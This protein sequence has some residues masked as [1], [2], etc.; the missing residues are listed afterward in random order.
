MS[1]NISKI[2]NI[3]DVN[4]ISE[5]SKFSGWSV[6]TAAM[7]IVFLHMMIRGSFATLIQGMVAST[8]WSTGAVSAGNSIFMAMYGLFAFLAG[9]YINKLG[10]RMTYTVHGIVMG[11]GL[12]L[13]SFSEEPWQ[14]WLSYAI[15]GIG[16]GAFWAP[17]TS[18]VRQWF[19]DKLGLAMGL[20]TGASG[21]SMF[22]GPLVSMLII[23]NMS[24]Q[25][26]MKVFG[27]V[28][29]IGIVI[30]AQF[31]KMRPE[32]IGQRPLGYEAFMAKMKSGGGKQQEEFYVPFKWAIRHKVF[33]M[34]SALWFC[35][36]FAEFIVFSHAINYVSKDLGYDKI[37]ATYIYCLIGFFFTIF[38]I[39]IG[40]IVDNLSKKTGDPMKARKNVLTFAYLLAAG[41]ALWLN[42]GVRLTADGGASHWAFVVYA[43]LFGIGFGCYIPSVAGLVGLAVGR[44]EMPPAWGLI[45]LIGMAGGAG[46]G[47][48]IAGAFR[49]ATGSY[50]VSIWLSTI[51]YIL[52]VVFVNLVQ[53][54][55]REQVWGTAK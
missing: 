31:T 30:G 33:W 47:P 10:C 53:Q 48:Y 25:V 4:E 44:K 42:Y 11:I 27:V 28:L 24:W 6:V 14:Y 39:A 55:S 7:V 9:T 13:C 54:P 41:M 50:F 49:D 43:V 1:E 26:M 32:D 52:A 22:L 5:K 46:L 51:F 34:L 15:V 18:M 12:I 37:A 19:I 36:N 45:S 20:T 8:G 21:A 16:S 38:A 2:D 3:N 35:S 23:S 40:N 29:I 17:V